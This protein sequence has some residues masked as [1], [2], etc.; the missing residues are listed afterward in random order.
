[1]AYLEASIQAFMRHLLLTLLALIVCGLSQSFAQSTARYSIE[2]VLSAPYCSNLTAGHERVAWVTTTE[3]VRNIWQAAFPAAKPV[4]LTTYTI[5][6]GQEL[7]ELRFSPDDRLLA[8]VRGGG[9]NGEGVSP[10]PTSDP[11]GAEQAIYVVPTDGSQKPVRIAVGS[12]PVFSPN[13]QT[14][15]FS[16]GGQIH[17]ASVTDIKKITT[18]KLFTAR[19]FLSD[20]SWSPDGKKVLFVSNR[21]YHNLIG[22]YDL[23]QKIVSWLAPG[24]DR[25]QLPVWSPDG[26]QVAFIRQPGQRHGELENIQ[27]GNR[28]AVWVADVQTGEGH[29]RWHSPGDDGGFAQYYPNEPMRWTTTNKLLFFSEHQGWMHVYALSPNGNDQP[30]DLTPGEYE[31]EE[32]FVTADGKQLYFSSNNPENHSSDKD[33]RH[34]WRVSLTEA[35]PVRIPMT[36]GDG[37]ETDPVVVENW[38]VWRSAGYNKPTGIAMIQVGQ[39]RATEEIRFPATLPN[40]FPTAALVEPKQVVIK[41][42]DGV[43]VHGQLFLPPASSA[44]AKHP[45][46]IFMHGGPMRQML[47]G[48]HYRGSY[49]ANAYAMNQY[50]AAKG[51]V[52]LSINYRAGIGYGR[53]FRRAD[54]QGPRGASEYQ[55]VLAGAKYLQSRPDVNPL[56][57]GLWGGSYGGYLTAMGLARNSDLFAAGVDLHG[58]HD[59]SWRGNHFSPGG[60][61]GIGTDEAKVALESSPNF[62]LDFWR[63]PCLFVHGDDDR[64]VT[65]AETVDLVQKLRDRNVPTEVLVFPDDVHSFLLHKNWIKTY[66]AMDAFFDKYLLNPSDKRLTTEK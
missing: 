55:D 23:A 18:Q 12:H 35:D 42:A 26:K 22:I 5:D 66:Q 13:G 63:S 8:F 15:L 32:T 53:A 43:A 20:F 25:D 40:R 46:L 56:K 19:G 4:K 37:I 57:I 60:G 14:L 17:L 29:E 24:V 39:R 48:W 65:F 58:V 52:V 50:L 21:D 9:K 64:N 30:V 1:M 2:D 61:W 11:A 16:Q 10:N 51:Y 44:S 31:A 28:F 47:L 27:G 54:K 6:D 34:I 49:Y 62:N 41:A 7:G 33:R 45:A 38:F 36:S 3:G 59:W